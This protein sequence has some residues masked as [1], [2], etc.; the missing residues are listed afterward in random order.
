VTDDLLSPNVPAQLSPERQVEFVRLLNG[1]H[2]L[3]L[4]YVICQLL[5]DG[6]DPE[7]KG[8]SADGNG[9]IAFYLIE[10]I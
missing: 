9:A 2:A 1:N 8:K 3:L 5:K 6:Q 10:D 4:R 7:L